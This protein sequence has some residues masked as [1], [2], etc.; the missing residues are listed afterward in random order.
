[1]FFAASAIL[2]AA[3]SDTAAAAAADD[4]EAAEAAAGGKLTASNISIAFRG[5]NYFVPDPQA[6]GSDGGGGKKAKG[7][8]ELQLLDGVTGSFR[9]GVLTALMV[10]HSMIVMQCGQR[11]MGG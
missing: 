9:P 7:G 11:Q 6:T 2:A 1:M 8:A 10:S 4:T 3:V 5:L